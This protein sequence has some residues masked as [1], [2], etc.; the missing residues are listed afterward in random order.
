MSPSAE[1]VRTGLRGP[2]ADM[3]VD[4]EDVEV[5]K[6]GRRHVVRVVVDRDGGVDLDLVAS[7]SQRVSELLDA[8]PLSDQLPGPFVLEVTSPGVNRPL[9][10][11]RHWRRA[12]GRLVQATMADGRIVAGR[13]IDVPTDTLA[14]VSTDSGDVTVTI[15]DV[16]QALVQVEFNRADA[17][18]DADATEDADAP[19]DEE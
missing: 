18:V 8:P 5:V 14:I 17:P 11:P 2:L 9:T 6:A 13:V 16:E 4:L 10:E 12:R 7:V 3:G 1:L 19:E 15:A